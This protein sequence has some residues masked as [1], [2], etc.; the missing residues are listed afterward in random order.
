[1]VTNAFLVGEHVC[2]R[3]FEQDD[4]GHVRRWYSTACLPFGPMPAQVNPQGGPFLRLLRC[5]LGRCAV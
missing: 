4:I 1:M 2:L 3:P 5:Q